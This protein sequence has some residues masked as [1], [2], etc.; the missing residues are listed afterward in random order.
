MSCSFPGC[1]KSHVTARRSLAISS[2][3]HFKRHCQGTP[4]SNDTP[5]YL[6]GANQQAALKGPVPHSVPGFS[7]AQHDAML[8]LM[9]WVEKGRAPTEIIAT[10]WANDDPQQRVTSQRPACM[11]P[12]VAKFRGGGGSKSIRADVRSPKNWVCENLWN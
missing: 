2:N 5:W 1:C 10:K 4:E 9:D 6:A 3:Y 7:D 8:A 11:Y 12:Q